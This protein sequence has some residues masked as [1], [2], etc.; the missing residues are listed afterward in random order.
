MGWVMDGVEEKREH[1]AKSKKKAQFVYMISKKVLWGRDYL[2]RRAPV[3]KRHPH[4]G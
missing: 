2:V 1:G 4:H 3:R